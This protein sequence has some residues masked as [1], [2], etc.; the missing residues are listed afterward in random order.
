[1]SAAVEATAANSSPVNQ[2]LPNFQFSFSFLNRLSS[3]ELKNNSGGG[4]YVV[5]A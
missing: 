2:V 4:A 1:L 3:A 5:Q